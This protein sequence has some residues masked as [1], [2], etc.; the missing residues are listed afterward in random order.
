[1]DIELPAELTIVTGAGSG[2]GAAIAE[3]LARTGPVLLVGRRTDKL[4]GVAER[5]GTGLIPWAMDISDRGDV[6]RLAD[7]LRTDGVAISALINN[8]GFARSGAAALPQIELRQ[9]WDSVI[10]ANL[11]GAFQLSMA[12]APFLRRPGGRIVNIGSIAAYTGGRSKG[13]AVY[14][15]SKGGINGLTVGLAREFSDEGITVNAVAPGLVA[16]T[17]FT[18]GWDPERVRQLVSEIPVGRPGTASEIAATVAFL[19]GPEAGYITGQVI[20]QNGGA[21]FAP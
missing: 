20:H 8:A 21:Y 6:D 12:V 2:I 14:A 11:T 7:K 10:A 5:G 4:I 18:S 17:E 16:E 9:N 13:S 19:C 3:R 1:M 15:A